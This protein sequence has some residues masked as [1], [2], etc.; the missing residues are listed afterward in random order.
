MI[1]HAASGELGIDL[2]LAHMINE[3]AKP[4][5]VFVVMS[6]GSDCKGV[7]FDEDRAKAAFYKEVVREKD[8]IDYVVTL[9]RH[10]GQHDLVL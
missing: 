2:L 4:R 6:G 1:P 5:F 9:R 3:L 10:C 7:Y 8:Y